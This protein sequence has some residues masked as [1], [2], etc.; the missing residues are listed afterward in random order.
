MDITKSH[1]F[2]AAGETSLNA[3]AVVILII[4]IILVFALKRK[5][6]FI[7][8]LIASLLIPL[9]QQLMLG[10]LHFTLARIMLPFAWFRML[11]IRVRQGRSGFRWNSLDTV[12]TSY[13]VSNAV[14]YSIRWGEVGAVVN[15]LG[16]AYD[17]LGIYF[18]IRFCLRDMEDVDR[19][20]KTFAWVVIVLAAFM[21]NEQI[22]HTNL[23]SV[24]GGVP[25]HTELRDGK[26]RAQGPFSHTLTAGTFAGTLMPVFYG[27]WWQ[28]KK[29]KK[30]KRIAIAGTA[31]AVVAAFCTMSSTPVLSVVLG[32][33]AFSLWRFRRY[34]GWMR[35]GLV[36]ML[37]ALHIVMNGPVWSLIGKIDL[38]GSS[39]SY[40]RFELV[41]QTIRRFGEWWLDGTGNTNNW[42]WD[43][44]DTANA[45]V[46]CA[47]DAGLLTLL[48]FIGVIWVGFRRLGVMRKAW[49]SSNPENARRLWALGCMLFATAVSFI[50][51]MYFDQTSFA[52]FA[53]LAMIASAVSLRP[54]RKVRPSAEPKQEALPMNVPQVQSA[55]FS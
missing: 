43:M 51:I 17:A 8:V 55:A 54:P 53:E 20:A 29:K 41:D 1:Y 45:Y 35:L 4:A 19:L 13:V 36:G 14:L 31:A 11:I 52:W 38:T 10:S 7:P 50:G 16:F 5:Y 44:W 42:G 6:I 21:V 28:N 34:L 3:A 24:F 49:S 40:H 39:S 15:R 37:I 32:V 47:T 48:L 33:F 22:T 18:L 23:F 25:L 46:N 27:L 2:G 26:P 12:F 9:E 30:N